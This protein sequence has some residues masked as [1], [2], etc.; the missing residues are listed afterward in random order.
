[1]WDWYTE[2]NKFVEKPASWWDPN[3]EQ[4]C[5]FVSF[6]LT[7]KGYILQCKYILQDRTTQI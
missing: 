2:H 7:W 4:M 1:M 5:V 6:C 3:V